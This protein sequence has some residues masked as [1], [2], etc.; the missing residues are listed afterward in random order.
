M[1]MMT[2][3]VA[4]MTGKRR[5]ILVSMISVPCGSGL[6]R[7]PSGFYGGR[8]REENHAANPTITIAAVAVVPQACSIDLKVSANVFQ[9]VLPEIFRLEMS[10]SL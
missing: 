3:V 2:V 8:K 7:Y 5:P 9:C 6:R 4:I 10:R 1:L